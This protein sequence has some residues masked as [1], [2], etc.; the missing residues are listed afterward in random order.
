MPLGK[1]NGNPNCV[2][3]K[4]CYCSFRSNTL[5]DNVT[6]T[7]IAVAQLVDW[8]SNGFHFETHESY[9]YRCYACPFA[10]HF[11]RCLVLVQTMKT[12]IRPNMDGT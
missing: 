9:V 11:T 10:N 7:E 3:E 8:R 4:N 12:G 6:S 1:N 2:C 5:I